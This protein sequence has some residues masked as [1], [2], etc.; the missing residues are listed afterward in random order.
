MLIGYYSFILKVIMK[1]R[2]PFILV[3]CIFLAGI[4]LN[5][6]NTASVQR[7]AR[8]KYPQKSMDAPMEMFVGTIA[9]A[10]KPIAILNSKSYADQSEENK[11]RMLS[12]LRNMAREIGADAVIEIQMLPK[13]FEGMVADD[14]APFPAWKPGNSYGYF[15]R[16]KA[17]VYED[18]LPISRN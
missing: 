3:I 4:L 11:A 18:S 2:H 15:M 9:R 14:K 17:V 8:D 10:H 16:G 12:I 5:G 1:A 13:R 7:L 6:C